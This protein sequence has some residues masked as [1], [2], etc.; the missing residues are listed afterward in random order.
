MMLCWFVYSRDYA[1]EYPDHDDA[2]KWKYFPRYWPF[3]PPLTDG[4]PLKSPVTRALIS[5]LICAW[6]IGWANNPNAAASFNQAC[7]C[8][9]ND[10]MSWT[11]TTKK[12]NSAWQVIL[13]GT[14]GD[15]CTPL[16]RVRTEYIVSITRGQYELCFAGGPSQQQNTK[17]GSLD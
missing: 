6:T 16:Q 17:T 7:I 10:L 8:L 14:T 11:T 13:R 9:F 15:G 1:N 5:S 3:F 2:I 4:F 12:K